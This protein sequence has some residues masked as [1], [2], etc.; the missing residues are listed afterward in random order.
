MMM[1]IQSTVY[2][3]L[4]DLGLHVKAVLEPSWFG[5]SGDFR[6]RPTLETPE[7]LEGLEGRNE[8]MLDP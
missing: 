4:K 7:S 2:R 5:T 1:E 3:C 6:R 8:T